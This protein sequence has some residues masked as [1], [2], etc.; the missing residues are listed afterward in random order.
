MNDQDEDQTDNQPNSDETEF[1]RQVGAKETRKLKQQ[2]KAVQNIW[3]GFSMFG[4][5]GWSVTIPTLLGILLGL[6][7]DNNYPG[8]QAW[9]LNLMIV[10][11]ILGCLNAWHWVS[12]EDKA[13]HQDSE[14]KN[15]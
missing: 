12:K 4:L 3:F 11:L 9:T 2:R 7:L 1:S 6:W 10:G 8:T 13:I 5:I 15:E 14:Q